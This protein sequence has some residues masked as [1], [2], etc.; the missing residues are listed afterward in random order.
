MSEK[1]KR[2]ITLLL[3]QDV[4]FR[5]DKDKDDYMVIG[6]GKHRWNI[7]DIDGA[8]CFFNS[9]D[10]NGDVFDEELSYL[11]LAMKYSW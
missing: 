9:P 1:F 5:I 7:R 10:N 4:P 3:R 2:I 11:I 6:E 8:E